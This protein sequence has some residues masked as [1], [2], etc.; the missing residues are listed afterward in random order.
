MREE[1][2]YKEQIEA[3]A[4][5]PIEGGSLWK[6]ISKFGQ[7]IGLKAVYSAL[8][9]YYAFLRKDTPAWAK[10]IITGVLTYLIAPIDAIPDLTPFLGFTDDLS[11]LG[12]ALATLAAYINPEVRVKAR[13]R[14]SKWFENIDEATLDAVDKNL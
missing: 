7:R 12:L 1:E 5:Q 13:E 11:I 14:L 4:D 8:L 2:K 9:L 3:M 6:K 10:R